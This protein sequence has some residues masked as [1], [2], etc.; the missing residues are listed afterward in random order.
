MAPPAPP[1]QSDQEDLSWTKVA[2]TQPVAKANSVSADAASTKTDAPDVSD[3]IQALS[4]GQHQAAFVALQENS[5]RS[6]SPTSGDREKSRRAAAAYGRAD[7]RSES[8]TRS[9]ESPAAPQNDSAP[10]WFSANML[11]SLSRYEKS[12]AARAGFAN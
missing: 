9:A 7:T 10:G 5:L 1:P 12:R 2:L 3:F 8:V 11:D 4:A 6:D